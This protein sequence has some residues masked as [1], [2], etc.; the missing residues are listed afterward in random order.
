[1]PINELRSITTFAKTAE[2]GSLRQA[3]AA[4]GI[5]PQAASQA[6]AQLEQHL[7]IRLFHRT[8]RNMSLTDEGQQF[9]EAAEPALAGLQRAMH[10]A[11]R[12]KDEIAGPL[13]IVGPRS[14][15]LPVL[16]AVLEGFCGE[17]PDVQPDVQLDDRIG[18]WVEDRVDV[19]FRIGLSPAE[20]VVARRLFPLQLIICAA[21]E[22]LRRHGA[23]DNLNQLASHRCSV[24]RYPVSGKLMPW[25]VKV[26][27]SPVLYE[28]V[29]ALCTNEEEVETRAVLAGQ[30]LGLLTGITAA[31]HI[32][33]GRLVP[34]LTPHVSDHSS[35]FV[36]YGS[37]PAQ[38]A[39]AR[40]FIEHAVSRLV[41]NKDFVLSAK[42]LTA[43]EAKG[44]KALRRN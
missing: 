20:G 15:F 32:R 44:R 40:A 17:H 16:W 2:L 24:F 11:R 29:P 39:R 22:Y 33:S 37:R 21:P 31:P 23:P 35:V 10:M 6:L 34:L 4:Q 12:A 30:V 7:G 8:T 5:T 36:Y 19:G 28:V 43:A 9:L 26:G 13:R 42:E 25:R 27:E 1:M 14:T 38:P 18:N 41:D 3:A